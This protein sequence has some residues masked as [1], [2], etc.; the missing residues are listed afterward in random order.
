MMAKTC[1]S[2]DLLLWTMTTAV[3]APKTKKKGAPRGVRRDGLISC[4][5][6]ACVYMSFE[7]VAA[8]PT[9][10]NRFVD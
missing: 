8:A 4:E 7:K 9:E 6:L 2:K 1:I 5:I 3:S 10:L